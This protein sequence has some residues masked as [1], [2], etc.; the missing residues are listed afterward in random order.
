MA[1]SGDLPS[2]A[3]AG[4]GEGVVPVADP[5][6]VESTRDAAAEAKTPPAPVRLSGA[7]FLIV[8]M[9]LALANFMAVLD[10]SIAN[11]SVPNIAGG[12]A[13]SPDEGTW[14]ITSY[15][16]AEAIT[17]PLTGWL[18]ARFGTVRVFITAICLFALFS[19]LCG[20][21]PSLGALVLFRVCQGLCGGPMIP[22]SQTL[23]LR[24][25][26]KEQAGQA[27]GLWSMTTV[28][29]PI[30]G[31]LLGGFLS[32]NYGWQ[33]VFYVNIPIAAVAGFLAFRNL[34][35]YETKTRP[36]PVDTVGLGLLVV[37]VSCLQIALDKGK[38]LDWFSSSFIVTLIATAVVGFAAFLIW[39]LTSDHPIVNL[40]V[41]R[42]RSFSTAVGIMCFSYA[43]FFASGVLVPLWL[44]TDLGYTAT[45]AGRVTAFNGVLAIVF[46]PIVGKIVGRVDARVLIFGGLV[47]LAA[48]FWSRTWINT[49]VTYWQLVLPQVL[50]GAG[51]PFFFIPLMSLGTGGLPPDEV[52]SGASLISFTRTTA[53]AFAVSL[54]TTSWADRGSADRVQILGSAAN[55]AESVARMQQPGMDPGAALGQFE[56]L[57]QTQAVMLA[58]NEIF[59]VIACLFLMSAL[60]VWIAP[61]P[62]KGAKAPA[63]AH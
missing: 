50:V 19:A 56:A 53:G 40:R 55:Q 11:V 18:A 46:S 51:I 34:A 63:G 12:L 35:P 2:P 17:V 30:A 41:F 33:W 57:V 22:L 1:Q 15:G 49:D 20:L 45:Q 43:A 39:E 28:V 47:W 48:V 37:W 31:P 25:F 29:A 10:T 32:D 5:S 23:L 14:V 7:A 9:G 27:I 42:H 3:A 58:T 60:I 8:G 24:V 52:A 4:G 36:A 44:Q 54:V 62:P 26:P 13:V 38:E 59:Q 61:R 21:A 6:T 16:V